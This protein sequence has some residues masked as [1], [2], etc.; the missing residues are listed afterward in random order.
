MKLRMTG[1]V[2]ALVLGALIFAQAGSAFGQA[3]PR[4]VEIFETV[5]A[6]YERSIEGV[7][8]YVMVTNLFTTYYKKAYD[9][10]RPY[11]MSRTETEV[12]GV[13]STSSTSDADLFTPE[14]YERLKNN[15]TYAGRETID[16]FD[17]HVLSIDK[18]EGLFDEGEG[19][20]DTVED[21]KVYIDADDWVLRQM[22]FSVETVTED[23]VM[24][25]EP[26][27]LFK[28]YRDVEGMMIP[29]ETISFVT[30]LSE[31]LTDEEREEAEQGLK[32]MEKELEQLPEGQ[33]RMVE[34]LMGDR[35]KRFREMLAEDRIEFTVR[36]EEVRVNTGME[37][38][39]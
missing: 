15:A 16:G 25:V 37:D 1:F 17:V 2:G 27:I 20:D 12:F 30:G 23:G 3:D 4:A 39:E 36:V 34:R 21:L 10:G 33:R 19:V 26:M 13:Q 9:N 14:N 11:F 18:L 32:E 31:M 35:L 28:D 29:F 7:D 38:W 5:R 6:H 8:D 22:V 24:K